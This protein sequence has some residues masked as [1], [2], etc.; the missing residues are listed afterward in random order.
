MDQEQIHETLVEYIR[1]K[2]DC[3]LFVLPSGTGCMISIMKG[4]PA[5]AIEEVEKYQV[6]M[7]TKHEELDI[8]EPTEDDLVTYD[9]DLPEDQ[10]TSMTDLWHSLG[11]RFPLFMVGSSNGDDLPQTSVNVHFKQSLLLDYG[12]PNFFTTLDKLILH[13]MTNDDLSGFSLLS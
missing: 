2:A 8:P 1:E 4:I 12:D 11:D 13:V 6:S 3:E 7:S 9:S 5:G 10:V